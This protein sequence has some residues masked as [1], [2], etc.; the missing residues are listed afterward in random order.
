MATLYGVWEPGS[1][2]HGGR[3]IEQV[4][5]PH[6]AGSGVLILTPPHSPLSSQLPD[7]NSVD[8]LRLADCPVGKPHS[9]AFSLRNF[10]A[11]KVFRFRWPAAVPNL[12]FSPAV[13]HLLPGS[14]K[15]VTVTF[16]ADAPVKLQ[17]QEVK[18]SLV[19]IQVRGRLIR[20]ASFKP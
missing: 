9:I 11:T 16:K 18:L 5:C 7:P 10:S 20:L 19:Q 13:G 4:M 2:E 6:S 1:L 15:D 12:T 17:P 8:E 3:D 14:S